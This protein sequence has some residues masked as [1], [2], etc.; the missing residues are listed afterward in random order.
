MTEEKVL[1]DFRAF[2]HDMR[3]RWSGSNS[4]CKH[5][6]I[7]CNRPRERELHRDAAAAGQPTGGAAAP[8]QRE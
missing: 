2:R 7:E 4:A 5:F 1:R 6:A 8:I 3:V